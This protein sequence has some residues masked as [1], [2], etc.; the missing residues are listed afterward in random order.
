MLRVL[1]RAA[2]NTTVFKIQYVILYGGEGTV[3]R[4]WREGF[5]ALER[6]GLNQQLEELSSLLAH[7]RQQRVAHFQKF[8]IGASLAGLAQLPNRMPCQVLLGD[9][10]APVMSARVE[11]INVHFQPLTKGLEC[12][13]VHGRQSR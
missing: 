2:E 3:F 9:N 11:K 4:P 13:Q 6:L 10:I 7:G 5:S 8:F 1:S 12:R